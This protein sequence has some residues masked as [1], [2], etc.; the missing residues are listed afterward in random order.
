MKSR[1]VGQEWFTLP[2]FLCFGLVVVVRN[3]K[4]ERED[5]NYIIVSE[6][7]SQ[8]AFK[9]LCCMTKVFGTDSFKK[10]N[11]RKIDVNSDN[12]KHFENKN[13]PAFFIEAVGQ[14][15]AMSNV[16]TV[17]EG[18]NQE[19]TFIGPLFKTEHKIEEVDIN[20]C[21]EYH[22]K[23]L[24]DQLFALLA[25]LL[26]QIKISGVD[27]DSASKLRVEIE[28]KLNSVKDITNENKK[29]SKKK[30]PEEKIKHFNYV[31]ELTNDDI[32]KYTE[33]EMKR[34]IK[35]ISKKINNMIED[36]SVEDQEYFYLNKINNDTNTFSNPPTPLRGNNNPN[37]ENN[38]NYS[39]FDNIENNTNDPLLRNQNNQ[40]DLREELSNQIEVTKTKLQKEE[41]ELEELRQKKRRLDEG[42]IQ[43]KN[44]KQITQEILDEK[45]KETKVFVPTSTFPPRTLAQAYCYKIRGNPEK[46][47]P[48]NTNVQI[49]YKYASDPSKRTFLDITNHMKVA[50]VIEKQKINKKITLKK[51]N[52]RKV[53]NGTALKNIVCRHVANNNKVV[54]PTEISNHEANSPLKLPTNINSIELLI[55]KPK[56]SEMN[57]SSFLQNVDRLISQERQRELL[58]N[59][60]YLIYSINL[61]FFFRRW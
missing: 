24:V 52:G 40:D 8:T 22:G 10:L 50:S 25:N 19:K 1:Q 14:T 38:T 27:I 6:N 37:L 30:E 31:L 43:K 54:S 34:N 45:N 21:I 20:Y 35:K 3:E 15:C 61:I 11:L 5:H 13:F 57:N 58:G 7:L 49:S 41:I 36:P 42:K 59:L 46:K 18:L 47:F 55:E 16:K 26:K 2:K 33:E 17:K 48:N 12:A 53:K 4:N 23:N 51:K 60:F 56:N 9:V 39:L 44:K 28:K 32:Q 29:F